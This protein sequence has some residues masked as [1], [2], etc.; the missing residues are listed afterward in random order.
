MVVMV[1][2]WDG[3]GGAGANAGWLGNSTAG[4]CGRQG[5]SYLRN[6]PCKVGIVTSASRHLQAS[7]S[8]VKKRTNQS[9]VVA[10]VEAWGRVV[11]VGAHSVSMGG[12]NSPTR[13]KLGRGRSSFRVWCCSRMY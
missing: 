6:S 7:H 4:C 5:S 1:A 8:S 9:P 10:P 3:S 12:F 11:V 2:G 13:L